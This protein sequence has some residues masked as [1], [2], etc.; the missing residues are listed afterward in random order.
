M[1]RDILYISWDG[2]LDP[3]GQS[4]ILSYI[5]NLS[6][7]YQIE[8]CSLEKSFRSK[9]EVD[10][11]KIELNELDITWNYSVFKKAKFSTFCNLVLLIKTV[12]KSMKFNSYKIIHCRSYMAMISGILG[13]CK[14]SRKGELLFDIRGFLFLEKLELMNW[15]LAMIMSPIFFMVERLLFLKANRVVTLTNRSIPRIAGM[16]KAPI[17]VIPTCYNMEF[18]ETEENDH[19]EKEYDFVYL[20]SAGGTYRLDLALK[21]F[22]VYKS[23]VKNARMLIINASQHRMC[24]IACEKLELGGFV[25]IVGCKHKEI[26]DY[27][28]R[29]SYGIYFID[30]TASK[31]AQCPTRFA[32]LLAHG[33]PVITGPGIGDTDFIYR[34]YKPGIILDAK[35]DNKTIKKAM[36]DLISLRYPELCKASYKCYY[37]NFRIIDGVGKYN[38][39]YKTICSG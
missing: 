30:K 3:L 21:V 11:L 18:V 29:C 23:C 38:Q 22:K 25:D 1:E 17:D 5:K 37:D 13:S 32:E 20:G 7:R 14:L 35:A 10:C 15:F 2:L 9:R 28:K 24:M 33:L 16:T 27:L 4:Q 26:G 8:I 36:K 39:I 31:P 34:K 19:S 12:R 6:S